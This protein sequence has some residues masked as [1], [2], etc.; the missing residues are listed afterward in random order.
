MGERGWVDTDSEKRLA[1]AMAHPC[2]M[3]GHTK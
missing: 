2:I 1:A 3:T